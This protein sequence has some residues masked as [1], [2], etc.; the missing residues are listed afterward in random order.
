MIDLDKCEWLTGDPDDI[1]PDGCQECKWD[2]PMCHEAM[3]RALRSKRK[4]S[5]AL[6]EW[7]DNYDQRKEEQ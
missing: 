6:K 1:D 3:A 7:L 4:T 5:N 2:P